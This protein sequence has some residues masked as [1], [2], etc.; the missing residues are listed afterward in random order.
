LEKDLRMPF[1]DEY[2]TKP[3]KH[4]YSSC[5]LSS[6]ANQQSTNRNGEVIYEQDKANSSCSNDKLFLKNIVKKAKNHQ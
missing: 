3:M 2:A 6:F 5:H 1:L 4:S